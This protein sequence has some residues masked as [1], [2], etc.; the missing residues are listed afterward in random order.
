MSVY[1]TMSFRP[2]KAVID[3]TAI[4]KNV[5]NLREHIAIGTE[6]IAVVKANA[7]GHGDLEVSRVALEAGASML[8]VATPEEAL[9]IRA[10]FKEVPILI[11]GAVP[12][13]FVPYAAQHNITLTVFS[14]HWIDEVSRQYQTLEQPVKVHIK[15]DSGMGRIGVTIEQE[16]QELYHAI[17]KTTLF[18]LDGIFTHFATADEENPEY[19]EQQKTKFITM[20]KSLPA[21]PRLVH[22]ANTAAALVKDG[23]EFD[24]VRYGISMYGL[25]PSAYVEKHLPFPLYPAMQVQTE[26]VHVKKLHKGQHVGYGATYEVEQEGEWLAT[27]PIGYADGLVRGLQGQEVLIRGVRAEIVGRVCMDQIMV[28]LP[29]QVPVGEPVTLIGKQG[30]DEVTLQE[31]AD[32]LQTIVYEMACLLSPRVTRIYL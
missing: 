18:E 11:L 28:K 1:N 6:I 21:K 8:A 17:E 15:V 27:L 31:W 14:A 29:F 32:R 9:H 2:T 23:V 20:V 10:T 16:L 22:A 4:R 3:L 7:Y 30:D 26:V 24:A 13:A 19:Y 12:A 5:E 25:S